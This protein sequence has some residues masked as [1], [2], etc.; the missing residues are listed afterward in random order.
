MKYQIQQISYDCRTFQ[1]IEECTWNFST[2][3]INTGKGL[4]KILGFQEVEQNSQVGVQMNVDG[5]LNLNEYYAFS[6]FDGPVYVRTLAIMRRPHNVWLW[7]YLFN[8]NGQP[9]AV[10]C[11]SEGI[12]DTNSFAMYVKELKRMADGG[13][14]E[15]TDG[16]GHKAGPHAVI[17]AEQIEWHVGHREHR[18]GVVFKARQR[19]GVGG[20]DVDFVLLAHGSRVICGLHRPVMTERRIVLRTGLVAGHK[21]NGQNQ[22]TSP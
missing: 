14:V 8:D 16:V 17:G 4:L 20:V 19:H 21:Q 6:P 7:V 3:E 9:V 10:F 22:Q 5:W 12:N 15:E 2:S 18:L 13:V 1:N 11:G